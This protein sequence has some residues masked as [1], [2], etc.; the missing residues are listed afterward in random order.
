MALNKYQSGQTLNKCQ[1]KLSGTF[2]HA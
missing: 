2:G 1:C